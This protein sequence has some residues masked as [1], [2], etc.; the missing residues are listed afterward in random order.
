[1]LQPTPNPNRAA[2]SWLNSVSCPTKSVC[3]AVGIYEKSSG[4]DSPLAEQY[5]SLRCHRRNGKGVEGT[6]RQTRD[7]G[8]RL[9]AS[10]PRAAA[11]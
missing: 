7:S 6:G 5:S 2:S 3:T 9:L 4:A 11:L 10:L 8:H 1:V